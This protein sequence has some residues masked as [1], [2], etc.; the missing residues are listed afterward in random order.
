[1]TYLGGGQI[2]FP[3]K[4]LIVSAFKAIKKV[5]PNVST[6]A[7]TNGIIAYP[8][9]RASQKLSAHPNYWLRD[10]NGNPL[11]NIRENPLETWYTWDFTVDAVISLFEEQC[12]D[13]VKSGVVDGCFV[14][15]CLNV[16][17]PLN[18]T[19]R[20]AYTKNKHTMLANLQEKLPGVLVC[21]SGGGYLPGMGATQVQNWG[22]G[23]DYSTREI[24]M[25]QRA[26]NDSIVF[27]AH[28]SAVC[29]KGGNPLDPD[30]QTELAAF[31]IA[32][33]PHAY[34][35]CGGWSGTK[36]TWYEV[37]S[38]AIGK[39]LGNATLTDG[40]Y[41]RSFA[42]GTHVTYDTKKESGSITWSN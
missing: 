11:N 18:T 25:L 1:M 35:M 16:P 23:G 38:K 27:F 14:D 41:T 15:G 9:Y 34:Y 19:V 13:M 40:V 42:S 28:G 20:D 33:G 6:L 32:A 37:Y 5:N 2:V 21:G 3:R 24:P 22:K 12:M 26:M 36:P 39:P 4:V 10:I 30:V 8:W 29:K 31:L 17:G 7:Y